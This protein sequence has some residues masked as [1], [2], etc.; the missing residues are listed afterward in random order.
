MIRA[1]TPTHFF[2][3]PSEYVDF[4]DKLLV[5]YSQNDE[6]VLEKTEKDA[7]FEGQV[8][9]YTLTQEETNLFK[10]DVIVEIQIRVKT[11]DGKALPSDIYRIPVKKVLNDE[12][13]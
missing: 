5:T 12:V 2:E 6:I 9:Y 10:A 13:L 1:S 7:T 4:V 11:A 8:F 3:L